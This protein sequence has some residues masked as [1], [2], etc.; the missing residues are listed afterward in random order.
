LARAKPGAAVLLQGRTGERGLTRPLLVA[1]RYGRG[2]V[3]ALGAQDDWLWQMHADI[4]VDDSTHELLWRQM[5]RW[6]VNDVPDRVEVVADEESAPSDAVPLRAIVRDSGFLR[7]NGV[8]VTALASGPTGI[9][10]EVPFDWTADRDGEYTGAFVP[11][12][13]GVHEVRVRAVAGRDSLVSSPTFVRVA[14]PM[15]EYFGAERRDVLLEQL[16]R[17]T[18]GRTYAPER[19]SDIAR[20]L[21]YSSSGATAVRRLDLWDAPLVLLLLL[22]L[23]GGE[24]VLRRRRGLT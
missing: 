7:R 8:T 13:P 10:Q 4:A 2:R 20:D 18:G 16:A 15:D 23:L 14:E 1:Q 6:L 24:W 3:L 21:N 12:G 5:L 17:E 9:V 22:A 11:A 19:A